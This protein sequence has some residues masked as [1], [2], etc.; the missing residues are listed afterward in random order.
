MVATTV[1][2]TDYG[3]IWCW[4]SNQTLEG[5]QRLAR[6]CSCLF[7]NKPRMAGGVLCCQQLNQQ[8]RRERWSWQTRQGEEVG[9]TQQSADDTSFLTT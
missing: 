5:A 3:S 9:V 4:G 6:D 2:T 7:G 1:A 8:R